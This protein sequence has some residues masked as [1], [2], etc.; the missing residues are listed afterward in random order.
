[1]TGFCTGC[2]AD[3]EHFAVGNERLGI[4]QND[5]VVFDFDLGLWIP[6]ASGCEGLFE[7]GPEVVKL[8]NVLP[9]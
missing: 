5:A 7:A 4:L 8:F 2:L 3:G 9:E 1:M 6:H